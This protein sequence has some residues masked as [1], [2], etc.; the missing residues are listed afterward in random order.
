[1]NAR[2]AFLNLG[3][4]VE[5]LLDRFNFNS[6]IKAEKIEHIE[7]SV[8][9]D[10]PY[11]VPFHIS[12]KCWFVRRRSRDPESINL[13]CTMEEGARLSN[14]TH[15]FT[16]EIEVLEGEMIDFFTDKAH[17]KG[18]IVLYGDNEIHAPGSYDKTFLKIK[19]YKAKNVTPS[20][21]L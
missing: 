20:I 8:M 10:L 7:F 16:E 13:T 3:E 17:P 5:A 15:D 21:V 9:K 11:N 12:D 18:S 1:L 4:E 2:N 6:S 14:Q 19:M